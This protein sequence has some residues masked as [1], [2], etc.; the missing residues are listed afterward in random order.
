MR[1]QQ[2]AAAEYLGKKIETAV[3]KAVCDVMEQVQRRMVNAREE[4]SVEIEHKTSAVTR[5]LSERVAELSHSLLRQAE[6]STTAEGQLS[7][8]LAALTQFAQKVEKRCTERLD[9][10]DARANDLSAVLQQHMADTADLRNRLTPL[11]GTALMDDALGQSG[12]LSGPTSPS[13]SQNAGHKNDQHQQQRHQQL[14]S[15]AIPAGVSSPESLGGA[16]ASNSLRGRSASTG[17]S[18]P[19]MA[20]A[21]VVPT[22]LAGAIDVEVLAAHD[23]RAIAMLATAPFI[24][25]RHQLNKDA[26]GRIFASRESIVGELESIVGELREEIA[27]RP[28]PARVVEMVRDLTSDKSIQ[29]QLRD[30]RNDIGALDV[31]K[32]SHAYFT[33]ALK[34]K[35]DGSALLIKADADDVNMRVRSV[36]NAVEDLRG[37][38]ASVQTERA[39]FR[40]ML[41]E[42]LFMHRRANALSGGGEADFGATNDF[43]GGDNSNAT[44]PL[45]V[46]G[47]GGSPQHT[48]ELAGENAARGFVA[49][50]RVRDP[51]LPLVQQQSAYEALAEDPRRA[52][53]GMQASPPGTAAGSPRSGRSFRGTAN[54]NGNGNAGLARQA[55]QRR[56]GPTASA[57]ASSPR[58]AQQIVDGL[59]AAAA[60]A[61][62][63]QAQQQASA[64][65]RSVGGGGSINNRPTAEQFAQQSA[66]GSRDMSQQAAR[67]VFTPNTG[68][69][70]PLDL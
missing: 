8:S 50:A 36:A 47:V 67:K 56:A 53:G 48:N 32:V 63:Q 33:D 20:A 40:S 12:R 25:L 17:G 14:L 3:S 5:A 42:V 52:G 10:A 18:P 29:E 2:A 26:Q 66:V 16:G 43:L 57:S 65:P 1:E 31:A 62:P 6:S 15:S 38:V 54:N 4:T 69:A 34:T 13:A 70:P 23:P 28:L 27:K 58:R 19:T 44:A 59:V 61:A 35:A 64:S 55:S 30:I 37:A 51:R 41:R 45:F 7:T 39:Q 49:G 11:V 68:G 60:A 24:A 9:S 46:S 21:A 22:S